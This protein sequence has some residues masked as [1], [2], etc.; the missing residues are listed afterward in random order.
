LSN[1]INVGQSGEFEI[2]EA[3]TL[4]RLPDSA[5][6]G[7]TLVGAPPKVDPND[8]ILIR[9]MSRKQLMAANEA[10]DAAGVDL[11]AVGL[12]GAY[13]YAEVETASGTLKAIDPGLYART[14]IVTLLTDGEV[15]PVFAPTA[16]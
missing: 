16:L 4:Q 15:K 7:V 11:R 1:G 14:Q 2:E 5:P 10:F 3:W 8:G 9:R 13:E 6:E 12:I